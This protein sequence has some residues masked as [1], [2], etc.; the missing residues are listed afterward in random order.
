MHLY[1]LEILNL[2]QA[3][4]HQC[5]LVCIFLFIPYQAGRTPHSSQRSKKIN[6]LIW[7][8]GMVLLIK[9]KKIQV[10]YNYK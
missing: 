3:L 10:G 1:S 8:L 6:F 9:K 7:L 4:Q 5:V 2:F